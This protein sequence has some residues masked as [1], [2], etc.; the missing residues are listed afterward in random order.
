MKAY[1]TKY[2]LTKGIYLAEVTDVGDGMVHENTRYGS[3]FHRPDWHETWESAHV[4][5]L[6]RREA[7]IKSLK[8]SLANLEKLEFVRP[9]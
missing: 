3:Y 4:D 8:K 2:A 6:M 5:A 1:I 9:E 7:K